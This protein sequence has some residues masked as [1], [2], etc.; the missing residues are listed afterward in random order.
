M[1]RDGMNNVFNGLCQRL[2]CRTLSL[3]FMDFWEE[4]LFWCTI[5]A[6]G[7]GKD[8]CYTHYFLWELFF[9]FLKLYSRLK[10]FLMF[11]TKLSLDVLM[12][13]N[14]FTAIQCR[15]YVQRYL[16]KYVHLQRVPPNCNTA[17]VGRRGKGMYRNKARRPMM[18]P[19]AMK[20][21]WQLFIIYSYLLWM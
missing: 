9:P 3:G 10:P 4:D 1:E 12:Q 15:E 6:V 7:I 19:R 16:T 17:L 2:L 18:R 11:F 20:A 14:A 8:D 13:N 5:L 21:I